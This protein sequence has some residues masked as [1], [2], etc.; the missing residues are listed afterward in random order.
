MVDLST[1]TIRR[2]FEKQVRDLTRRT[3]IHKEDS[4]D[5]QFGRW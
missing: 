2:L 4:F 5:V 3:I 1:T